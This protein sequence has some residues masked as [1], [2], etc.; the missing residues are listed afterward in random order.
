M[1]LWALILGFAVVVTATPIACPSPETPSPYVLIT[2]VLKI[3]HH[4]RYS[5]RTRDTEAAVQVAD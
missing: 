2:K 4:L 1:Q 3:S 5:E